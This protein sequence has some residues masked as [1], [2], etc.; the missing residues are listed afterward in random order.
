PERLGRWPAAFVIVAFAWMELAYPPTERTDPKQLAIVS[1]AYAVVQLVGM[2][3]YGIDVWTTR[4]DG[5]GVYF[6]MFSRLSPWERGDG[7]VHLRPPLSGAPRW[8]G[9]V[10]GSIAVLC[11]GI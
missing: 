5:F 1:V 4:A 11:A 9:M 10:G 8:N 6:N 2:V 3:V 7:V